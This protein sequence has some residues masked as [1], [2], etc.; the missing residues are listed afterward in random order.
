[1][2]RMTLIT[3]IFNGDY[4]TQSNKWVKLDINML[5]LLKKCGVRRGSIQVY[6]KQNDSWVYQGINERVVESGSYN[7]VGKN[8]VFRHWMAVKMDESKR[9]KDNARKNQLKKRNNDQALLP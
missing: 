5:E 6:L 3:Y 2:T 9:N 4:W 7:F 1:M 8:I